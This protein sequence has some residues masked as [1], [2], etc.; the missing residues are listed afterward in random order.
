MPKT[1]STGSNISRVLN[2]TSLSHDKRFVGKSKAY[3][4]VLL[5]F[6]VGE[7]NFS[8]ESPKADH[9]FFIH[10]YMDFR[11]KVSISN[12]RS[13]KFQIRGLTNSSY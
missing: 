11:V 3:H 10:F 8:G 6:W 12:D 5:V 4:R 13:L 1:A 9:N 7:Q 2:V